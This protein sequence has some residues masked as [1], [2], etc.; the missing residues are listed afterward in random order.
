MQAF[1]QQGYQGQDLC[2]LNHCQMFLQVIWLLEI[3]DGTGTK[4]LVN[5]WAGS[6]PMDSPYHWPPTVICSAEWRRWQQAL[7]TCFGLDWW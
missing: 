5:C 7:Q 4:I 6:H 2:E 1:A 3:C